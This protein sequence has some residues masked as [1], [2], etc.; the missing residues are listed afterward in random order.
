MLSVLS[1][2]IV[3]FV[4]EAHDLHS[5]AEECCLVVFESHGQKIFVLKSSCSQFS[6][7]PLSGSFQDSLLLGFFILLACFHNLLFHSLLR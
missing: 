7:L 5:A 4:A 1:S 3:W 2:S 6:P